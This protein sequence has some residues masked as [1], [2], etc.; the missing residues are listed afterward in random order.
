M[1]VIG[2]RHPEPRSSVA[3][4]LFLFLSASSQTLQA[5]SICESEGT[6]VTTCA[7]RLA[8]VH[9]NLL[10]QRK[11]RAINV[12]PEHGQVAGRINGRAWD[13]GANGNFP[14]F[15]APQGTAVELR[16]SL[17]QWGAYFARE[18]A[19][20]IE[21]VQGSVPE[22]TDLPD[23]ATAASK[24]VDVWSSTKIEGIA[25][26][27]SRQGVISHFGADYTVSEDFLVG[28][29]V[30]FEDLEQ[31]TG[32]LGGATAA[33]TAYMIGPYVAQR[34]TENLVFDARLA[35]GESDD[36][37]DPDGVASRFAA[38]RRLAK[39]RL[40]GDFDLAGWQVS[41]SAA[42]IHAT[43]VPEGFGQ[44]VTTNKL[45]LGPEMR[46]SFQLENGSVIEPFLH[47]RSTAELEP[48]EGL[49]ELDALAVNGALGGGVNVTMPDEYRIQATTQFES[50]DAQT[51]PNVTGRVQLTVPL[52]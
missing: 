50:V 9:Q 21:K 10:Q 41:S 16:T 45:S 23:P 20:K 33:G 43:E 25:P 18:D 49:S 14:L 8:D 38:E 31:Q 26:G 30:E 3:A 35:W 46:R 7:D 44:G 27:S 2:L 15:L 42:F 52:P 4:V 5:A 36:L 37:V 40:K 48:V 17:S 12:E 6:V 11:D 28:A 39:A 1:S 24:K 51:D 34:L 22:G 13:A 47:Y 19:E 29:S 32:I